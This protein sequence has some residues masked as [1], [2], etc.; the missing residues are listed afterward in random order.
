MF[1][2]VSRQAQEGERRRPLRHP[3]A[4]L[5]LATGLLMFGF[6]FLGR[7]A[8][9]AYLAPYDVWPGVTA[10]TTTNVSNTVYLPLVSD[11]IP[12]A[13]RMGYSVIGREID[14]YPEAASLRAGW[15]MDWTVNANPR[16][17]NEIEFVQLVGM[18]QKLACPL[19][20][21]DAWDR[22]KCPYEDDYVLYTSQAAI[23]AAAK[24]NPGSIWLVGNEMDRRDWRVC[25][26]WPVCSQYET[27]GQNEM[28]PE[29]Y[30][31]A[32]HDVYNIIKNVDPTAQVAIGG[33]IQPT[34]L[35]L[36]YLT[37]VWNAYRDQ[38][39]ADMPVDVWNFHLYALREERNGYGADIPPG[40]EATTGSY[41][42]NDCKHMD[43]A[44]FDKL[45]RAMRQW[46]KERGQQN[47]PLINTE[48]GVLY[49]QIYTGQ[50]NDV[51]VDPAIQQSVV[52]FMV[53]TFDYF[54]N[55]K[56]VSLGY[57]ADDYRLVQRWNWFSLAHLDID[58]NTGKILPGVNPW[59]S[60][61][62][63]TT[64]EI[65]ESGRRFR[66]YA[67]ENMDVLQQ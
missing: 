23:E 59:A 38:Y 25:H 43:R 18:H 52:D 57:P 32:Y 41:V 28:L 62:N 6:M 16:R 4:A 67:L 21:P 5:V 55:T 44:E 42:A 36:E 34:P 17:P 19:N 24:A 31:R 15:Y 64:R 26:D 14:V 47:K 49:N 45:V 60:L 61:F 33:I 12:L 8:S 35:R 30:A 27:A 10:F 46:M 7:S 53:W 3:M 22:T 65:M 54:V 13:T 48:Y 66:A 50:C 51:S 40:I 9:G 63:R 56:D 58:P 1:E 11:K 29:V 37:R 2:K 20:S 39:G